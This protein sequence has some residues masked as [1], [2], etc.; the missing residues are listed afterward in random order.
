MTDVVLSTITDYKEL[1]LFSV[2]L[3][4]SSASSGTYTNYSYYCG[5][6]YLG[7]K[8]L[9]TGGVGSGGCGPSNIRN[10]D[11]ALV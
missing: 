2:R 11:L 1:S 4:H 7:F 6:L 8:L 9:R 5:N 10:D 3:F